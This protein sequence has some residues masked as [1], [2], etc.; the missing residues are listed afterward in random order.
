M[1][2]R[3]VFGAGFLAP[4]RLRVDR[5]HASAIAFCS[6]DLRVSAFICGKK[7]ALRLIIS[8]EP[9]SKEGMQRC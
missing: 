5:V 1:I 6:F 3:R 8:A 7:M 9:I 4:S 2:V